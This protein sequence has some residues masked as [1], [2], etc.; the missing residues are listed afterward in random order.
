MVSAEPILSAKEH[1][2][3]PD[4][5]N[6][7]LRNFRLSKS[8]NAFF[9]RAPKFP[10][11]EWKHSETKLT[12]EYCWAITGGGAVVLRPIKFRCVGVWILTELSHVYSVCTQYR[13]VQSL[14]WAGSSWKNYVCTFPLI[15]NVLGIYFQNCVQCNMEQK[16][17][18]KCEVFV[19]FFFW[20]LRCSA[21]P[22]VCLHQA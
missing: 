13:I 11:H 19:L 21:N 2:T 9:K 12:K 15:K 16:I 1:Y 10:L 14:A 8:I 5:R 17:Y 20:L 6:F 3:I 4:V 22:T 18:F 7:K